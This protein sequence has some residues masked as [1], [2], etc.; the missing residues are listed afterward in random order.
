M[1]KRS[2]PAAQP[3]GPGQGSADMPA[4]LHRLVST[5]RE[6]G[7]W[8]AGPAG[9]QSCYPLP[10]PSH[11]DEDPECAVGKDSEGEAARLGLVVGGGP[12]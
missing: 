8:P 6:S 1:S 3:Q 12:A 7:P 10:A 4:G 11:K 9:S 2:R 5:L